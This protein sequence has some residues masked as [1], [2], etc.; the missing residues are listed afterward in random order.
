MRFLSTVLL[1]GWAHGHDHGH[2]DHGYDEYHQE[3]L[4]NY[5]E[6]KNAYEQATNDHS[7]Q[8]ESVEEYCGCDQFRQWE[9]E[10][11]IWR[12][13]QDSKFQELSVNLRTLSLEVLKTLDWL[14]RR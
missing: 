1:I 6:Y 13:Y 10:I 4:N 8:G 11:Q 7:N 5:E 3:A 12:H 14:Y 9:Q 2:N